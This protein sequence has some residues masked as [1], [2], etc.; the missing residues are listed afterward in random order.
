MKLTKI[1]P[2]LCTAAFALAL[3]ACGGGGSGGD[4]SNTNT[5]SVQGLSLPSTVSVVSAKD[6]TAAA[7]SG[8]VKTLQM[9]PTAF[10]TTGTDYDKAVT[11]KY[12]WD[13]SMESLTMVNQILC[14]VDQLNAADMVNQGAYIALVDED[15]C[16]QGENGGGAQ[17]ADQNGGTGGESANQSESY[18]EWTVIV[19]R[20]SDSD[21]QIVKVW[22]PGDQGGPDPRDSQDVLV[23]VTV[24]E[25][26]SDTKPFGDFDLKFKGVIDNT[27]GTIVGLP[28]SEITVMQGRLRTV[29]NAQSQPQFEFREVSGEFHTPGIGFWSAGGSNVV[30]DDAN[31]NGGVARTYQYYK[32]PD[33]GGPPGSF[34]VEEGSYA[35][36]FNDTHFY[37]GRDIDNNGIDDGVVGTETD[38]SKSCLARN[39]F[40]QQ[41]WRYG[42]FHL[43]DGT[44]NGKA[45]TAGQK[46]KLNAGFP[47]QT[48]TG[49]QGFVGYY[50]VWLDGNGN[51]A[52]GDTVTSYDY[53]TDQ[54]KTY[55][56]NLSPGK[57]HR[58]S[59]S[60]KLLAELEGQR[61]YGWAQHS[62][63]GVP[64]GTTYDQ[65]I[66]EVQSDGQPS[67]TY[68][69]WIIG[70]VKWQ[71]DG[72][73]V[74][75]LFS[76][77]P[78]PDAEQ[79]ILTTGDSIWLWSDALGGSVNYTENGSGKVVFFAED[80]VQAN[81]TSL[82]GQTLYCYDR[83]PR[84]GALPSA[85]A[86]EADLFYGSMF[87]DTFGTWF[88]PDGLEH[89]YTISVSS[90]KV[91]I[92]D[93]SAASTVNFDTITDTSNLPE[94]YQWG[95]SGGEMSPASLT[96]PW[97]M[98]DPSIAPK[99]YRWE[100][101]QES[102]N[103]LITVSQNGTV[104]SFDKPLILDYTH[105]AVRDA[106]QTRVSAD[107]A[108][109]TQWDGAYMRLEYGGGGELWGFPWEYD[110]QT[111]RW[112]TAVNLKSGVGSGGTLGDITFTDESANTHN[113]V[114]KQLE[115]EQTMAQVSATECTSGTSALNID[116][117][118]ATAFSAPQNNLAELGTV[119]ILLS[120][121]PTV[122]DPPAVI[123]G[124]TQE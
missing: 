81:E 2:Q 98:Y 92:T 47:I 34:F 116:S 85:P 106:N 66:V 15:S 54:T 44:F 57:L 5:G 107:T 86:D 88:Q 29:A 95:I 90:G 11:R 53:A 64:D 102:W 110:P 7:A 119:S 45:V 38:W 48:L 49:D 35:I 46:V 76:G 67:P 87:T 94:W 55:T 12:V 75:T 63:E 113:F 8:L 93:S 89:Q 84:G 123:A 25:S 33:M 103:K 56:I 22:V 39:E 77:A 101:G 10:N 78:N 65:F 36:A 9:L 115:G 32:E 40:N 91:T 72:P 31:G 82:N 23:E 60:G 71:M 20:A 6:D 13:P 80:S 99:T 41:I 74:E 58:R 108:W 51:V 24:N 73:P 43:N 3:A 59:A 124:E 28:Q 122:N 112:R 14:Y 68:S 21:P 19:T 70:G 52:D 105:A 62:T 114:V 30:F 61:F 79:I 104:I 111:D 42:L 16:E 83:C 109:M 17:S 118:L 121:K 18:G 26:P 69:F 27:G 100:S 120:D 37:R 96:N 50:G 4:S 1:L 117:L 97:D